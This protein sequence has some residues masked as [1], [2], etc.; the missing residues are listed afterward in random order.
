MPRNAVCAL[1][2]KAKNLFNLTEEQCDDLAAAA[3]VSLIKEDVTFYEVIRKVY[4]G[5]IRKLCAAASIDERTFR[6]YKN[7]LPPKHSLLAVCAALG[8]NALQTDNY[9]HM[10]GYCL[11]GSVLT[12]SVAAFYLRKN[13]EN[14]GVK[15][16]NGIN[17]A[18]FLMGIS[19]LCMRKLN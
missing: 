16:L 5:S 6:N 2:E 7:K 9:L 12:D 8:F 14:S 17:D 11:S 13:S 18:L 3:G 15:T 4:T 19:P 10:F 1:I